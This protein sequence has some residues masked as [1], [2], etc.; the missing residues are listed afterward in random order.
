VILHRAPGSD[1]SIPVGVHTRSM[2]LHRA[3]GSDVSILVGVNT[4]SMIL[5]GF[6]DSAKGH[7]HGHGYEKFNLA[8]SPGICARKHN[9]MF[10]NMHDI[11]WENNFIIV[12]YILI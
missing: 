6:T 2:L 9:F 8:T 1:V 4:R 11:F 3:P 10:F 7:G 5:Q 12:E